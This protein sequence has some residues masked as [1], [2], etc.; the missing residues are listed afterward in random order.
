MDSNPLPVRDE[1][2]TMVGVSSNVVVG[3]IDSGV[4]VGAGVSVGVEVGGAPISV[5]VGVL[6]GG[7]LGVNVSGG[8]RGVL[9]GCA[10]KGRSVAEQANRRSAKRKRSVFFFISI[11]NIDQWPGV[12]TGKMEI[13]IPGS[14]CTFEAA[15]QQGAWKYGFLI[16]YQ[17]E[18]LPTPNNSTFL[19]VLI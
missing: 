15:T 9:V 18:T 19:G 4:S 16:M 8:G 10:S 3:V 11:P 14:I 6:V 12:I 17:P 13:S 2:G 5:G 1:I 7:R